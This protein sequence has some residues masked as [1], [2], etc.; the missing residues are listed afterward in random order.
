MKALSIRQPW[1]DAIIW[2]D[3]DVE[4]RSWKTDYRGPVLI[5]AAKAWGPSEREDLRFVEEVTS[6]ELG[7]A[8]E[9]FLGGIVGKAEIV[10]CVTEMD[11]KW[12]FGRYGFVLKNAEA[13]PFQPCKGRLGFFTPDFTPKP[14]IKPAQ[15]ELKF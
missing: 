13:L 6:N 8:Y 7:E 12:F 3:K 10:D 9:P 2:G 11:S 5:H 15:S 4:N 14:I 1:A